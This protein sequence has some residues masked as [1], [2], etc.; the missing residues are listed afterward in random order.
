M[1]DGSI[2]FGHS[3]LDGDS[4]SVLGPGG[5]KLGILRGLEIPYHSPYEEMDE[6]KEGKVGKEYDKAM[7]EVK[8][9]FN[10]WKMS[11]LSE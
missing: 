3:R 5:K 6:I 4:F 11:L 9:R 8:R 7:D 1:E 2:L 10:E